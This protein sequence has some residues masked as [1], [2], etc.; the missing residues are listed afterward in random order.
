MDPND[1]PKFDPNYTR[2]NKARELLRQRG[3]PENQIEH[4]VQQYMKNWLAE[5]E[6]KQEA[7]P[8]GPLIEQ[9]PEPEPGNRR[10]LPGR[11]AG[12]LHMREKP[13]GKA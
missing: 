8:Y 5:E 2:M 3:T 7:K 1:I 11:P 10:P 6:A 13:K 9:G 4:I 12:I